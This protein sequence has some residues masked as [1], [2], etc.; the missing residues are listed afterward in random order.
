[1]KNKISPFFPTPLQRKK[2]KEKTKIRKD[3]F[4]PPLFPLKKKGKGK[5]GGKFLPSL[6]RGKE[7]RKRRKGLDVVERRKFERIVLRIFFNQL[8]H[9]FIW[10][11]SF[12]SMSDR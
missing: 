2:R 4:F 1:M 11:E 12:S 6:K 8:K 10:A 5:E 3:S 9:F 7:R